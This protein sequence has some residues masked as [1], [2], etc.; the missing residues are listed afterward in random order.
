MPGHVEGWGANESGQISPP[1]GLD[2]AV[3]VAGGWAFSLALRSNGTVA[4]WGDPAQTPPGGLNNVIAIAAGT[5]SAALRGDGTVVVWGSN[6]PE[7]TTIPPRLSD[8]TAIAVSPVNFSGQA[9]TLA[10]RSNGTVAGWGIGDFGQAVVPA[11]LSQVVA[12]SPGAF[13]CLALKNDATVTSWGSGLSG[14]I[15]AGLTGV[16]AIRGGYYAN[17]AIKT[18]GSAISWGNPD[19]GEILPP[20]NNVV[21]VQLGMFHGAA[22]LSSGAV[23]VFGRMDYG[24]GRGLMPS[25]IPTGLESVQAIAAGQH[26][27]L[28]ITPRPLIH[29]ITA[30]L[31][32]NV[33]ASVQLSVTATGNALSY[34]WQHTGTNLPGKT[35]PTLVIENA[36]IADAGAYA[37]VVTNPYGRATRSSSISFPAPIISGLPVALTRYRGETTEIEAN[38][39]G[40]APFAFQWNKNGAPISG[41]NLAR[42]TLS[43][44]RTNDTGFFD[45]KVTDAAGNSTTSA[46][47]SLTVVDPRFQKVNASF[48]AATYIT[49]GG[50]VSRTGDNTVVAGRRNNGVVDRALILFDLPAAPAG[51]QIQSATLRLVVAK[52]PVNPANSNFKLHRMFTE[53]TRD[54]NW[55]QASSDI[56][57][58]AD[59]ALAG[60]DFSET[61]SV[62][63]L[64]TGLATYDFSSPQLVA[65]L[66]AWQTKAAPN[67]G[68]MLKNE[69]ELDPRSARHFYIGAGPSFPQLLINYFIPPAR[70]TMT[71]VHVEGSRL[72]FRLQGAA[73]SIYYIEG[74]ELPGQGNWTVET[75]APA[76]DG[77]NPILISLPISNPQRFYRVTVD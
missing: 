76:G 60:T 6:R 39:M 58:A 77:Q 10:L 27:G 61:P 30:P 48:G 4:S 56:N 37:A 74:R 9:F 57:W 66:A 42:L 20:L 17:T 70:P 16:K 53:W 18:D 34:Q 3:A 1:I 31:T 41:E 23:I 50:K 72:S 11:G 71:D 12:I 35:S 68:W 67:F 44:L 28:L 13:D 73:G 49:T 26:H 43:N 32:A 8:V 47:I 14:Q 29:F 33:G 46:V 21:D 63:Q 2:D 52:I 51:A 22:L 40:L 19:R 55:T 69:T 7:V 75:N 5:H 38:V 65:D 62:T 36:Q 59:G 45:L 24:I 54:A 64:V 15:P 25:V